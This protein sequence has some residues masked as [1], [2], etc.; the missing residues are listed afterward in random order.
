MSSLGSLG[1]TC[2]EPRREIHQVDLHD[3]PISIGGERELRAIARKTG[4][5]LHRGVG[6]Q[7]PASGAVGPDNVDVAVEGTSVGVERDPGLDEDPCIHHRLDRAAASRRAA[8]GH[9]AH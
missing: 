4:L 2:R 1:D 9:C 5:R 7:P 6:R 8:A 3:T